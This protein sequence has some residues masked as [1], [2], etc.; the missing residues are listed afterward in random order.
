MAPRLNAMM[1]ERYE[2]EPAVSG[3]S[4]AWQVA[5]NLDGLEEAAPENGREVLSMLLLTILAIIGN[6]SIDEGLGNEPDGQRALGWVRYTA[7]V[8]SLWIIATI[9]NDREK[10]FFFGDTSPH[11]VLYDQSR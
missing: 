5:G 7:G 1:I 6:F 3:E 9:S 10:V 2:G 8:E 4:Q 11:Q